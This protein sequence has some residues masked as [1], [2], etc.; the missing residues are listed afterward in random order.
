MPAPTRVPDSLTATADTQSQVVSRQQALNAG[1]SPDNLRGLVAAGRWVPAT[2]GIFLTDGTGADQAGWFQWAWCG[3][4][5]AGPGSCLGLRA[6][7]YLNGFDDQDYPIHI[8]CPSARSLPRRT[9]DEGLTEHVR[10]V[11]GDREALGSPPRTPVDRTVLDLCSREVPRG[12]AHD[13]PLRS[14]EAIRVRIEEGIR[15]GG[16]SLDSLITALESTGGANGSRIR[17]HGRIRSVL[18]H[19]II[20]QEELTGTQQA[21]TQQAGTPLAGRRRIP[22]DPWWPVITGPPIRRWSP[23]ESRS[24]WGWAGPSRPSRP[25]REDLETRTV[26]G[27]DSPPLP[28]RPVT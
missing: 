24:P 10:F 3:L 15:Y 25:S 7:A 8:W 16:T 19:L 26:R 2:R 5:A 6:A 18:N 13:N 21:G 22:L 11:G 28:G 17:G 9:K 12:S 23:D 27:D 14:M 20:Q 4:L 1:L